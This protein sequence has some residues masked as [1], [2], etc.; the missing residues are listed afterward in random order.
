MPLISEVDLK[1]I[2]QTLYTPKESELVARKILR[3]N[4]NF[5]KYAP[6]IGYRYY[7]RTGSAKIFAAGG[8]AKDVTFVGEDG[9][10]KVQKVYDIVT[11]IRYDLR[12]I[13][14]TQVMATRTDIPSVRLDILRIETARR[15]IA[16]LEN[17]LVLVGDSKYAIEGLLNATGITSES[18]A[19]TVTNPNSVSGAAKKNWPN[20]TPKEIL[21][22]LSTA[23]T[24]AKQK[25]LFNPD[26]LVLPSDQY[27]LLDQPYA[28]N[29]TMTIRQWLTSQGVNFPKV[30][31]AK[32]LGSDFNLL[33]VDA[34]L[35][36]D[37]SPEIAEIA[38]PRELELRA[39]IYDIMG[40]SEQ[41]VMESLAGCMIRHPSAIYVGKGI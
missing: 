2:E 12:E 6:V 15:A 36:L 24:K 3:V 40:N 31:V 32:E 11:G 17:K 28:D 10:E 26:T 23:R 1:Q 41:V 27:D 35:V 16:E 8:S 38:V 34:L 33:G 29:S 25:G 37:S 20:K 18:V 5:N 14:A 9:G 13:E 39:P 21:K 7:T 19:D 4:T 22:D 30:F